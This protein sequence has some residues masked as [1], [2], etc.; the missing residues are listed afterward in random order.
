MGLLRQG[1]VSV[2]E[3]LPH[4]RLGG[5]LTPSYRLQT[6]GGAMASTEQSAV[7]EVLESVVPRDGVVLVGWGLVAEWEEPNG[8][9]LLTRLISDGSN[10]WQVKGYFWDG[11]N[12]NW[13]R[14]ERVEGRQPEHHNPGHPPGWATID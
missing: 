13:P 3:E 8:E 4:S 6:E 9:R 1:V 2:F 5:A 11:L 12:G 14:A 10:P 7:G